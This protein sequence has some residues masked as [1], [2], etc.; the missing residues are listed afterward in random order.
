VHA[1][2]RSALIA[3]SFAA[4]IF[5][6]AP[7][8]RALPPPA[9]PHGRPTIAPSAPPPSALI[10]PLGSPID[11]VL[12]EAMGSNKSKAG[13]TIRMH[14]RTPL[15]VNEITLAPAD[16][17]ATLKVIGVHRAASGDNDGSLQ[18]I[19]EPLALAKY[20]ELPIRASHE[21][22]TIEHT[23]GQL[24]TRGATDTVTDIFVPGAVLFNA[25]RKGRD[26]VL[27]PG[28]ILRAQTAAT[29]DATDP[30]AISIVVPRP[31][32]LNHDIPHADFT[33]SPIYT[34]VPPPPKRP[35]STPA[36]ARPTAPP[37]EPAPTPNATGTS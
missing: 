3:L 5:G 6:L 32:L 2:A 28:A 12:D 31:M 19:I 34:P 37:T 24:S 13:Q 1:R 10:L 14:L 4:S 15:V 26:F 33:P 23:R 29:V 30:K 20:G 25:L 27:P 36:P 11:F 21:Y 7:P 18:I 22:L 35:K 16:A 8:A 17:P 9:P